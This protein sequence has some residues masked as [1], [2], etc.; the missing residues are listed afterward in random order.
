MTA[1]IEGKKILQD[2]AVVV[3]VADHALP[4]PVSIQ[5][6]KPVP[7]KPS[8]STSL[9][10]YR[11]KPPPSLT[12]PS[13][14]HYST[15]SPKKPRVPRVSHR[16]KPP[17]LVLPVNPEPAP[18]E[19]DPLT[20]E[21]VKRIMRE[22]VRS[23][24]EE[25]EKKQIEEKARKE[26]M[27]RKRAALEQRAKEIRDMNSK[28][29]KQM[30][31]PKY[32][33]GVNPARPQ[34]SPEW[35]LE[36]LADKQR[37][38]QLRAKSLEQ[39]EEL[40]RI[41]HFIR[42]QSRPQIPS[43]SA[44]ASES[45]V[46]RTSQQPA[47]QGFM[48]LQQAKRREQSLNE[49]LARMANEAKRVTWLKML[50]AKEKRRL[51]AHKRK[52]NKGEKSGKRKK[53]RR[54][55]RTISGVSEGREEMFESSS[56]GSALASQKELLQTLLRRREKSS[57][58][59]RNSAVLS[60]PAEDPH[61]L[62]RTIEANERKLEEFRKRIEGIRSQAY[63]E[64]D[65][66]ESSP[67][68]SL[69]EGRV[70][71]VQA[72]ARAFLAKQVYYDLLEESQHDSLLSE[73]H[74]LTP[75]HSLS[76][77]HLSAPTAGQHLSPREIQAHLDKEA[78]NLHLNLAA[79]QRV[80]LQ[81]SHLSL[82][83]NSVLQA[84]RQ[85]DQAQFSALVREIC[86]SQEALAEEIRKAYES[87]LEKRYDQL[88]QLFIP[89]EKSESHSPAGSS[90]DERI[91]N[92]IGTATTKAIEL[93]TEQE[94]A[95]IRET[96]ELHADSP[97]VRPENPLC[98]MEADSPEPGDRLEE[99]TGVR[100]PPWNYDPVTMNAQEMLILERL[101]DADLSPGHTPSP[102]V[103]FKRDQLVFSPSD[104]LASNSPHPVPSP[105]V[106]D[107]VTDFLFSLL[108]QEIQDLQVTEARAVEF[109]SI[110]RHSISSEALLREQE[111]LRLECAV[112]TDDESV[113]ELVS[114]MLDLCD[115]D[116]RKLL[117][118]AL[119]RSPVSVLAR[120]QAVDLGLFPRDPVPV[121]LL[122]RSKLSQVEQSRNYECLQHAPPALRQ[123]CQ[124]SH[125]IHN[126]LVFEAA[127]EAVAIWRKYGSKGVPMPWSAAQREVTQTVR[128]EEAK[129]L[130][131]RLVCTWNATRMGQI[132]REAES[133]SEEL[134][135]LQREERLVLDIIGETLRTDEQWCD[136]ED[137][138]TQVKLD[139]ADM[140]LEMLMSETLS[141]L[142]ALS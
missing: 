26:E 53:S 122:P 132:P 142:Y 94:L 22:S 14:D 114:E 13:P 1:I 97:Q 50:E 28:T 141:L 72:V 44:E 43:E 35:R 56:S 2:A 107:Q 130:A 105:Q 48:K 115:E 52:K 128:P 134:V 62:Q 31:S 99:P 85:E 112:K 27:E 5:S 88:Q 135:Q 102:E 117:P 54:K 140:T 36:V 76:F 136:Y 9:P 18:K 20:T 91:E 124:D 68:E 96:A 74:N 57:T 109:D 77:D 15:P 101:K 19:T 104:Q 7:P 113:W 34:D 103:S 120:L 37:R 131:T 65:S 138:E 39:T 12:K 10:R 38:A 23:T 3:N 49:E 98:F 61:S 123:I 59:S 95:K 139:L 6:I 90:L 24:L 25:Q 29:P 79:E 41:H 137:E 92:A 108:L 81:R 47:I 17:A 11:P 8:G 82:N 89:P 110:P 118:K 51:E 71:R 30:F 73:L 69:E 106:L 100:T 75:K 127:N 93:E 80:S 121:D 86:G 66:E 84:S 64:E 58:S 46:L 40:R 16:P 33:W 129:I 42:Q 87:M 133:Q 119:L 32:A 21:R 111:E 78:H 63:I 60:D 125:Q 83:A 67:Q 55:S 116:I 126:R 4:R 45:S 70:A